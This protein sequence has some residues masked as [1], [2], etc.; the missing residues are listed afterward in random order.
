MKKDWDE[1]WNIAWTNLFHSL[2]IIVVLGYAGFMTWC[3]VIAL[4]SQNSRSAAASPISESSR[5]VTQATFHRGLLAVQKPCAV[6]NKKSSNV[7]S[8]SVFG[9]RLGMSL[10]EAKQTLEGSGYFHDEPSVAGSCH[11]SAT[12]CNIYGHADAFTVLVSFS[13]AYP[14]DNKLFSASEI[15]LRFKVAVIPYLNAQ[16]M[17]ATFVKLFG[18]PDLITETDDIGGDLSRKNGAMIHAY[19]YEGDF[20]ITMEGARQA[21]FEEN[22]AF[23][24]QRPRR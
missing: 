5:A 19:G 23:A 9:L 17:R 22:R 8:C 20:W 10:D 18:V 24:E 13:P 21:T 6:K 2:G 3:L 1:F 14:G 15:V 7:E 11:D 16:S 12:H 4:T